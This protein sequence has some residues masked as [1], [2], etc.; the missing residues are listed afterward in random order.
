MQEL[1]LPTKP[2]ENWEQVRDEWIRAVNDLVGNV[3]RWCRAR[4]WPT[5][6][7]EKRMEDR[8]LGEYIVP[9]LVIQVDLVKLMLEPVAR[10][11]P[12]AEGVVDLYRMPQFADVASIF[13]RGGRWEYL[14]TVTEMELPP[15]QRHNEP[16]SDVVGIP[17]Q[18]TETEFQGLIKLLA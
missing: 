9:A 5:R 17:G 15:D 8:K 12:G 3:E 14:A 11:V 16:D 7:I 18:F 4:D 10:F 13:Y 2:V 1:K 6:R